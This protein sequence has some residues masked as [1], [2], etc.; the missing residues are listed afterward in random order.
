MTKSILMMIGPLLVSSCALAVDPLA[1]S[2][3]ICQGTEQTRQAHA[4]ALVE[5]GGPSSR[6]TGVT[7]LGQLDRGCDPRGSNLR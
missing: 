4:E 2:A 1:Q 5:D 3:A 6:V 7:L